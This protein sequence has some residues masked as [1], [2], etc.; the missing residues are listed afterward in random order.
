MPINEPIRNRKIAPASLAFDPSRRSSTVVAYEAG[1]VPDNVTYQTNLIINSTAFFATEF[2]DA[3]LQKAKQDVMVGVANAELRAK[4]SVG[5]YHRAFMWTSDTSSFAYLKSNNAFGAI[6]PLQAPTEVIASDGCSAFPSPVTPNTQFLYRCPDGAE[7]VWWMYA[8]VELRFEHADDIYAARLSIQKNGALWS[9]VDVLNADSSK[10]GV[11]GLAIL[12]GGV[13]VPLQPG[14]YV[15]WIISL[16]SN[17]IGGGSLVDQTCYFA[18]VHG[19][20]ESCQYREVS[21]PMT[22]SGFNAIIHNI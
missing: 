15:T 20:R 7:G 3:I 5:D 8:H 4:A 12:R 21:A 6:T 1:T 13:H 16:V 11:V 19:H 22:G 18:T 9:V 10:H 14:D 2:S 17:D